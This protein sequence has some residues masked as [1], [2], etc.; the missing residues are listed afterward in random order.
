MRTKAVYNILGVNIE[1]EKDVIGVYFGDHE[2]AKFWRTVLHDL[3]MRGV[4]D[5][6]V[7]C[8]DNLSGFA[9]AIEDTFPRTDVQL[10][11][12]HQMRNSMKY[13]SDKD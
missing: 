12:V 8:I 6:L 13:V 2:S 4:Q 10:F 11:L 7:A 9:D 1:G 3:Q 5:I